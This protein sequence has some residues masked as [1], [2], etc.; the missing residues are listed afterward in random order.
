MPLAAGLTSPGGRGTIASRHSLKRTPTARP[1]AHSRM[2]FPPMA[3]A[4]LALLAGMAGGLARLGLITI[5]ATFGL[6][7]G[8]VMISGFLGTLIA[9]ERAV[10]LGRRWAYIGPA[11]TGVASIC[12]LLGVQKPY[13]AGLF[14]V[15]SLWAVFL[16][17][18]LLRRHRSA[19][20]A[21]M[22]A[23]AVFWAVGNVAWAFD[24]G[25]FR[26]VPIWM[27]YLSLTIVGERLELSRFV[28]RRAGQVAPFWVATAVVLVG[29]AI[30]LVAYDVSVRVVGAGFVLWA[31][32]LF[33]YDVAPRALRLPGVQRFSAAALLIAHFWLGVCG[34]LMVVFGGW[35]GI[36]RYDT[37][38]HS[39]FVGFVMSMIFGHAPTVF[40]AVLG[41]PVRFYRVHYA[42][43]ALLHVSLAVRLLGDLLIWMPGREYGGLANVA[44]ILLFLVVTV[45]SVLRAST[46]ARR[47]EP[48]TA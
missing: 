41:L 36:L 34:I 14:I 13:A 35:V 37:I 2:R 22:A 19:P 31:T 44:A 25:L 21:M 38:L 32:W 5:P 12:L 46:E 3:L 16:F 7:H 15:G 29:E 11:L 30:G 23:G 9:V 26:V 10:A 47:P 40:P 39:F 24:V 6:H 1:M 8:P 42:H 33:R 48:S 17:G 28:V 43:L 27:G 20:I 45:V 18:V 4:I